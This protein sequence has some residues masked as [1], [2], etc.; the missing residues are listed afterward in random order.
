MIWTV[1]AA[2]V[3]VYSWKLIGYL[4]PERFVSGWFRN[5][6][7]RVTVV[8]LVG[9]VGVQ[10]FT[11]GQELVLDARFPALIVAAIMFALRVPYIIVVLAAAITAAAIRFFLGF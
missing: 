10:G 2:S 3:A 7:E 6:A 9:L 11:S 8:L 1:L 4:V 5:F